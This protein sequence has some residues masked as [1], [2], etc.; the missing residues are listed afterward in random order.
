MAT[1][2]DTSIPAKPTG[3]A[4]ELAE[5]H[6]TE[7]PLKLYGGWFCPFVQRAWIVL[8][9]KHIPHQ[10][11]E[12]NPYRK[13]PEFLALNP[14]GLVPTL[15]VPTDAK[16]KHPK[17]L[18]ES[19]V[20]CEFLDEAYADETKFGPRLLPNDVYERARCRLWIDHIASRIVPAFYRFIQHTP[21]KSYTIEDVRSEF[22]GHLKTLAKEMD[23]SGPW[24]LGDRFSLVDIMLAPWAKRL[25]LID[26][27]KP[28][29]VGI[30][31]AGQRGDDEEVWSRWQQWFDAITERETV[32]Q[33]WSNDEQYIDAYKRYADD[34]TSSEV[35]KATRQ[36]K[37]LP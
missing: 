20:I 4:A 14:R 19:A 27:Y 21:D 3:A 29:G 33:T 30:T 28:G 37:K 31:V 36:G 8:A 13:D 15:A 6:S 32:K 9:E 23:T 16:G 7:H 18:Y 2:V 11:V 26:H 22:H 1:N 10:Y 5:S 25:F 12:I 34:T 24:F 17:P 35:G